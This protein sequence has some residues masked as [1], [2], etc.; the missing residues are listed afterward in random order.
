[1]EELAWR[2]ALA[3]HAGDDVV[4]VLGSLETISTGVG[5]LDEA[6]KLL[7]ERSAMVS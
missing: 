2:G 1:M 4:A 7:V 5:N 6:A 3:Q